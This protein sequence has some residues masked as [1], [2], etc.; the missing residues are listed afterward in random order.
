MSQVVP[1]VLIG[2]VGYYVYK[3]MIMKEGSDILC[4]KNTKRY[5]NSEGKLTM[6]CQKKGDLCHYE[7]GEYKGV[8][9]T[10]KDNQL[11]CIAKGIKCYDKEKEGKIIDK[12][13]YFGEEAKDVEEDVE[14]DVE[15]V[16]GI[17]E[18]VG[19]KNIIC[20]TND[21]MGKPGESVYRWEESTKTLRHYPTPEIADSW[22]KNWRTNQKK[23]SSCKNAPLGEDMK[24]KED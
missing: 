19:R 17:L 18:T 1:L 10:N 7:D 14:D 21:P 12:K 23:M 9:Y 16:G 24:A 22:D 6:D 20:E 13:C 4:E 5:Y 11:K 2:A 8:V 15:Y 3:Q